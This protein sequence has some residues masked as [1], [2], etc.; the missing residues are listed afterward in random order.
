MKLKK[1][2]AIWFEEAHV[3]SYYLK[4]LVRRFR[5]ANLSV[6]ACFNKTAS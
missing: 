3:Y 1:E 5:A 2:S 6:F 4:N